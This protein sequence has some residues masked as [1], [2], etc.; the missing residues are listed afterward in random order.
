MLACAALLAAAWGSAPSA[1]A[2][3]KD[4]S[5][6]P[7]ARA[8]AAMAPFGDGELVLFGGEGESGLLGDTWIWDGRA[9]RAVQPSGTLGPAPRTGAG[10]A[11]DA[12]SNEVVLYGGRGVD[13]LGNRR[14]LPLQLTAGARKP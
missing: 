8:G 3:P 7:A 11:Y 5:P 12:E 9:W 4:P 6:A 1:G 13:V 14:T 2:A 10:M